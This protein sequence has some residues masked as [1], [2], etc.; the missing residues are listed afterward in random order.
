[1]FELFQRYYNFRAV[2]YTNSPVVISL[3]SRLGIYT[4]GNYEYPIKTFVTN[5]V[6]AYNM[7]LIRYMY[8]RTMHLV[9]SDYYGYINSDII[10]TPNIFETLDAT[11]QLVKEGKVNQNVLLF[12]LFNNSTRLLLLCGIYF[13][14]GSLTRH[15]FQLMRT[16]WGIRCNS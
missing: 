12:Y 15:R 14:W 7:P 9:S 6:N 3:C 10:M 5:R 16:I 1:M 11:E 2:V 4:E 8:N 13:D